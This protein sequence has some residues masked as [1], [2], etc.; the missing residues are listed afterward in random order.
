MNIVTCSE[1]CFYQQ[2]GYC[3]LNSQATFNAIGKNGC[4]YYK[5]AVDKNVKNRRDVKL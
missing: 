4:N 5:K 3:K 2:D 1:N